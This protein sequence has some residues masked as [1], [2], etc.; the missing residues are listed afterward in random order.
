MARTC[1]APSRIALRMVICPT[2][3]QPHMA[4]VS[5]GWMSHWQLRSEQQASSRSTLTP[6]L[7]REFEAKLLRSF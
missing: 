7:H 2:G 4:T 3:P 1:F 5:V 6:T